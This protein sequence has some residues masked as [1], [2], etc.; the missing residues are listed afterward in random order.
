MSK[1]SS[2]SNPASERAVLAG[3][4][5]YGDDAWVD[6]DSLIEESTFTIDMNKVM[7][8]CIKHCIKNKNEVDFSTIL[9]SAQSLS[10]GDYVNTK[11]N[12]KHINGILSTPIKIDNVRSHAQ[13]IRRLQFARQIQTQLRDIYRSLDAISGDESLNSILSL[14][15]KPI[16]DICLSYIKED[17]S[18]PKKLGD[19]IEEYI[20]HLIDNPNKSLGIPSGYPSYDSAIGGGFRRKCVDLISARPKALRDGSCIY[21]ENG[22]VKI[23]DV[24]VGDFV[25]HPFK[26]KTKVMNIWPHKNV[27][28]FRVHFLDGDYVDCCKDHLWHVNKTYGNKETCV[29]TTSELIDDVTYGDCKKYK[30]NVPLPNKVEFNAKEVA[31]DPYFIGV[32]LGDGSVGNN[33]CVYHTMDEEI[34]EY[35]SSY[36]NS[37]GCE[38]KIDSKVEGNKVTSYRINSMQDKLREI[39]IFGCNCYNKFIPKDYIYNSEEV[40]LSVLA[41]LLDTD[42]DCTIDKRSR[43]S[44]SR[45]CSV[46]L[47]LCKDVK[48]I[49]QSLGGLCSINKASTTLNGKRFNSYRCEIRLPKGINP[50]RLTR[51]ANRFTG[52]KIGDLKR[53]ISKIEKVGVDN[54]RCLTLSEND[55]LFMTE[56]YVVTHNTGKSCIADNIALHISKNLNIPVLMLDTEMST[57]DHWNRILANISGVSINQIANGSFYNDKNKVDAVSQAV[58]IVKKIPYHYISIA[59]K[60]FEETLSI[61]RRWLLKNVGYD[62]NGRLNDCL[63]IY[64]YLKLMTSDSINNNMAEFQVLGFQITNLHN[65]CVENDCPCLSFVQLNRDGIT[66]ES[67]DAVSGSDR[68]IWLCTSFSIFKNKTDEE[69]ATDGLMNGNKKLIPIVSRHGPGIEDSGYICLNMIGENAKITEVG[70]IR[71]IKRNEKNRSKGFPATDDSSDSD[72]GDG[73]DF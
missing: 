8:N 37:L 31:V 60:P 49:V 5:Q 19:S 10:L 29:K 26:G 48:E 45:F 53:T 65:F 17:D 21:T 39:G 59:G 51:K 27:D 34:H 42:G 43:N 57:E 70:T 3:V 16:Q 28:I 2:L 25:L 68:L 6:V 58:N 22:P 11:D 71:E 67:T 41:G 23:E 72:E 47:Q 24:K 1:E 52:R 32:L 56:N 35:M 33:T 38:V 9:S 66:K 61:A 64:D 18:S 12:L 73:E 46:S 20:N 44:R 40:R 54:A 7:Y 69:M 4:C 15:E 13:K 55:G 50:F 63:I 14:A 62:E 30:W 36:A